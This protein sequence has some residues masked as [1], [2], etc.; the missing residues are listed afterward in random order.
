LAASRGSFALGSTAQGQ[1][2]QPQ[3]VCTCATMTTALGASHG[4]VLQPQVLTLS[5]GGEGRRRE[6]RRERGGNEKR[7][8]N[9][10]G[11]EWGRGVEIQV[12]T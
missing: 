11:R 7:K 1:E 4:H 5:Q 12:Y 9:G 8:G 3:V 6:G 10:T 2:V